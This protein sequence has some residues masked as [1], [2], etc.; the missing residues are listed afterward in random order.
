[1]KAEIFPWAIAVE[2]S[3]NIE[4]RR[5]TQGRL[6]GE[7]VS[8]RLATDSITT[9][10]RATPARQHTKRHPWYTAVVEHKG[11]WSGKQLHGLVGILEWRCRHSLAITP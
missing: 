11:G 8:A 2:A 10:S 9:P 4:W 3:T 7:L 5:Q 6:L 1:M